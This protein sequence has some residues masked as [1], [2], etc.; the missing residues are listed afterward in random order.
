M[1]FGCIDSE[2][3]AQDLGSGNHSRYQ[4]EYQA[5]HNGKGPARFSC[6]RGR[7]K[8]FFKKKTDSEILDKNNPSLKMVI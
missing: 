1:F 7:L 6:K 8:I 3:F 4:G 2:E 5:E